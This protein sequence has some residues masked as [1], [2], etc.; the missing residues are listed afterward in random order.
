MPRKTRKII[1]FKYFVQAPIMSKLVLDLNKVKQNK[2]FSF[3][4]FLAFKR[5]K[6][7]CP[8]PLS[9]A[10][11]KILAIADFRETVKIYWQALRQ[12]KKP[13]GKW[14]FGIGVQR[15]CG[16]TCVQYFFFKSLHPTVQYTVFHDGLDVV[17]LLTC[18]RAESS[19]MGIPSQTNVWLGRIG[20]Q[21]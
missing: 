12:V 6:K 4:S 15:Q 5:L 17:A 14:N 16:T 1:C 9:Q 18:S 20:E 2:E 10:F 19:G 3:S 8:P 13:H 21:N 7:T 11:W